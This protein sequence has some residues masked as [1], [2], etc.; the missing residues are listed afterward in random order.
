MIRIVVTILLLTVVA[1]AATWLSMPY[2]ASV[3]LAQELEANGWELNK[4]HMRRPVDLN[5]HFDS[6]RLA[7]QPGSVIIEASNLILKPANRELNDFAI[8]IDQL[9]IKVAASDHQEPIDLQEILDSYLALLPRITSQGQIRELEI[10]VAAISCKIT[11][12]TWWYE[13]RG[14][15][16]RAESGE[17]PVIQNLN[18]LLT[19]QSIQA[20]FFQSGP[21]SISTKLQATRSATN[22]VLLTGTIRTMDNTVLEK[23]L[24]FLPKQLST[25]L[26]TLS[27]TLEGS[28][29]PGTIQNVSDLTNMI[30]G[31]ADIEISGNVLW[32][33]NE[34][35]LES[36]QPIITQLAVMPDQV[37]LIVLPALKIS[38]L[39][40]NIGKSTLSNQE[41]IV[42]NYHFSTRQAECNTDK[43]MIASDFNGAAYSA[44]LL[45][46]D[47]TFQWPL[48]ESISATSGIELII[49]NQTESLLTAKALLSLGDH[50][51][52]LTA[53]HV[54][55]EGLTVN[56]LALTHR[57]DKNKGQL[58]TA[59]SLNTAAMSRWFKSPI[60]GDLTIAQE[61]AWQGGFG[62]VW[63]EWPIT[64]H[65]NIK[66]KNLSGE[67]DG[68]QFAG[69]DFEL[70]LSGWSLLRTTE[71]VRMTWQEINV[72]FPL[73]NT[74]T[75]FDLALDPFSGKFQV[76]GI[77]AHADIL[78]GKISSDNYVYDSSA[79][80]GEVL[81]AL[82]RLDLLQ[83]LSLEQE[84]FHAQGKLTGRL[85]VKI[86]ANRLL[87]EDGT[88]EALAPGGLIQYKPGDSVR[89]LVASNA[90][91]ATVLDTLQDFRYD[92]LHS[93]VDF[94]PDGILHLATN[95]AG[96]NP[97]FEGGRRV[98]FNL[99]I[100]EN[101]AALLK[102]LRLGSDLTNQIDRK[103]GD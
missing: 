23:V 31:T 46:T 86:R 71:P 89:N 16:I 76:Q 52:H 13:R 10:C 62:P 36:H 85:P 96:S 56:R 78:G 95:L 100:E 2:I 84:E 27:A 87:I 39:I 17:Q 67:L 6:V 37:T 70:M 66:A 29:V 20:A 1:A 28:L 49:Q 9:S 91:M 7:E 80:N 34:F 94:R 33:A 99:N 90:Q 12:L 83:V 64:L 25:D 4:L 81:L 55:F 79:G 73:H 40:P 51:I 47:V 97:E 38:T 22:T 74:E 77:A 98:N 93:E 61:A 92:T 45:L 5:W 44:S 69:G 63:H 102:S 18:L 103:F 58:Q 19:D 88:I 54:L 35:S 68:Y 59:Y 24:P 32:D 42:C 48:H 65:S 21:R 30:R 101:V 82:D 14:L 8:S 50:E 3:M 11:K 72:G 60:N 26:H 75:I 15:Q 53:S 41:D 43:F 57:L